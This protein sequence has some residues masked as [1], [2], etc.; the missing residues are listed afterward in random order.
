M[1]EHRKPTVNVDQ[2]HY[3]VTQLADDEIVERETVRQA[4]AEYHAQRERERL[5]RR[6]SFRWK[7]G[8]P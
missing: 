6:T 1:S 3:E 7:A 2:S 8:M 5:R 4:W